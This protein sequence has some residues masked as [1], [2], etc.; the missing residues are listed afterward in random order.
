MPGSWADSHKSC[1]DFSIKHGFYRCISVKICREGCRRLCCI[2]V[3]ILVP[4]CSV[5]AGFKHKCFDPLVSVRS[6]HGYNAGNTLGVSKVNLNPLL[7]IGKSVIN[8]LNHFKKSF[9]L[10]FIVNFILVNYKAKPSDFHM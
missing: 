8:E 6:A 10:R 5:K 9:Y 4:M 7:V 3:C 2:L 1:V